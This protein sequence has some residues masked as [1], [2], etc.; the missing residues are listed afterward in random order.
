ML[1]TVSWT[2]WNQRGGGDLAIVPPLGQP[3]LHHVAGNAGF[4][5][6]PS[7]SVPSQ[8]VE[9]PPELARLVRKPFDLPRLLRFLWQNC[10]NHRLLVDVHYDVGIGP[11]H[12]LFLLANATIVAWGSGRS[13]G[14]GALTHG[15]ARGQPF[16]SFWAGEW[17]NLYELRAS[18][19]C[20]ATRNRKRA[21]VLP[22]RLAGAIDRLDRSGI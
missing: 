19:L 1:P 11:G 7:V 18:S 6:G 12:G 22:L 15:T 16:H 4:V 5:T 3:S 20:T 8:T 21:D 14:V 2:R 10:R 9:E 17:G 13:S